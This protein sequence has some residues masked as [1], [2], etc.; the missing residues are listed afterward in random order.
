M[1]Q[2]FK[3][4]EVYINSKNIEYNKYTLYKLGLKL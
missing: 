2:F 4:M 1:K 3:K